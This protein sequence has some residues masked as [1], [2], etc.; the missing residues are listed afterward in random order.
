MQN[1][2]REC[3]LCCW[4]ALSCDRSSITQR[5]GHELRGPHR[6]SATVYRQLFGSEISI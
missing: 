1:S 5:I 3:L 4:V 2:S 6:Y